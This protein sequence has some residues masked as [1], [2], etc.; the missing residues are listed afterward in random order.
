[1]CSGPVDEEHLFGGPGES[2]VEPVDVVGRE[3]VVGHVALIDVDMRPLAALRL[4]T[5]HGITVLHLQRIV[6]D[7]VPQGF[8]A[9]GLEGYVGIVLHYLIEQLLLLS[10]CQSRSLGPERVEDGCYRQFAVIIVGQPDGDVGKAKA[11]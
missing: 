10:P 4:V 7:I 8:D 3:H 5:G 11:V 1:M 6:V 9:V 2:G